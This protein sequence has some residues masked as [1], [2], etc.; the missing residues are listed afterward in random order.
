MK[1]RIQSI[2]LPVCVGIRLKHCSQASAPEIYYELKDIPKS[3]PLLREK[4]C[5]TGTAIWATIWNGI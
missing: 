5:T 2:Y 1:L 3:L 4:E